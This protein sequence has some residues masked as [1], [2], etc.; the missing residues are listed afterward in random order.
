MR[1]AKSPTQYFAERL[2][3]SLKGVGTDDDALIR[4][5]V[6]RSEVGIFPYEN[7]NKRTADRPGADQGG[8]SNQI[9]EN[10]DEGDQRQL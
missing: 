10:V 5:I 1:I 9:Q 4:I 2:N 6:S 7:I 8:L 3:L